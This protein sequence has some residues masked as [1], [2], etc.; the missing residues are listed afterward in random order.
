[1]QRL[2]ILFFTLV[3]TA[4]LSHGGQLENYILKINPTL[5]PKTIYEVA[6]GLKKYPKA[7]SKI[8]ERESTFNPLA[9]SKGNWGLMG[10][11]INVWFS[12]NPKYNLIKLGVIKT[13]KELLTINGNLKAGF[14]IWKQCNKSYRKYRGL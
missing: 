9:K 13:K 2:I 3:L 10:V 5:P 4:S 12:S 14:Y 7:I 1:M 11:N 8:A 6:K